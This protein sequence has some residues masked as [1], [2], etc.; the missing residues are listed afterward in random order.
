MKNKILCP[1][2]LKVETRIAG[3]C[4]CKHLHSI[5]SGWQCVKWQN[6]LAEFTVLVCT[7]FQYAILNPN[8]VFWTLNCKKDHPTPSFYLVYAQY[9]FF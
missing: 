4:H 5:C 9:L 2:L 3:S 6:K 8:V 7:S 1:I